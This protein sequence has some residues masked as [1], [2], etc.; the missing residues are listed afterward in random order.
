MQNKINKDVVNTLKSKVDDYH[1]SEDK[2][3]KIKN[4][5]LVSSSGIVTNA[6]RF[7]KE[8]NIECWYKEN[9][10]FIKYNPDDLI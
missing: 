2:K 9:N 10:D 6:L 5:V 1:N 4:I 7:A 8:H 3:F